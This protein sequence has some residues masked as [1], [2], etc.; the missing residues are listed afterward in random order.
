MSFVDP[1][2]PGNV[3]K[4]A[5][6]EAEMA[7]ADWLKLPQIAKAF[8]EMDPEG[9]KDDAPPSHALLEGDN[10]TDPNAWRSVNELVRLLLHPPYNV[11]TNHE[12]SDKAVRV[13]LRWVMRVIHEGHFRYNA[14]AGRPVLR[15]DS[16]LK[17][18]G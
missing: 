12:W 2:D 16:K 8:A 14:D 4:A 15:D 9:D 17:T 13:N 10:I 6:V 5:Q 3:V 11:A 7:I 18:H 1:L